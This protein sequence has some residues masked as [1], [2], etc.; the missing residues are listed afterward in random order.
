M[1]KLLSALLLLLSSALA[2]SQDTQRHLRSSPDDS[3]GVLGRAESLKQ[4]EDLWA[5]DPRDYP[6]RAVHGATYS[7][8]RGR[9]SDVV[10][11]QAMPIDGRE[12]EAF[13]DSQ[14]TNQGQDT[15]VTEA[16][17]TYYSRLA[18]AVGRNPAK[19]PQFLRMIHAFHFVDNV[20]ESPW[21]CVL[22][23]TIYKAHRH[24]Y[25]AAVAQ[26]EAE[27]KKESL[28]C[29]NPPDIP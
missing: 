10:L 11:I 29:R 15:Q 9:N 21:L 4:L 1:R 26:V 25:M 12:M 27:Y 14:D 23:S 20:D 22:A 16:Y 13:Y 19:L 5:H 3:L 28:E 18:A 8:L 2:F 24:D 6:H 17:N 7:K